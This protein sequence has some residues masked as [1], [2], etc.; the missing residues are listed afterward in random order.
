MRTWYEVSNGFLVRPNTID[1]SLSII[2][3][4]NEREPVIEY[5]FYE[6][7]MVRLLHLT[8][9]VLQKWCIYELEHLNKT[10]PASEDEAKMR[11]KKI[12]AL[13]EFEKK[14]VQTAISLIDIMEKFD[15]DE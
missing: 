15:L 11:L 2:I 13:T 4:N 3:T 6:R 8:I 14:L 1:K 9:M 12:D 10:E 5:E 7:Q